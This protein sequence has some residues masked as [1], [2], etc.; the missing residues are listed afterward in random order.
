MRDSRDCSKSR[1]RS[2]SPFPDRKLNERRKSNHFCMVSSYCR[3]RHV[4]TDHQPWNDHHSCNRSL[5]GRYYLSDG[6]RSFSDCE[7]QKDP[8]RV[9]ELRHRG[10]YR[11]F[12]SS[13][14]RISWIDLLT[15][16][17]Y[18]ERHF[19]ARPRSSRE[20]VNWFHRSSHS[21]P[22]PNHRNHQR[23]AYCSKELRVIV[24]DGHSMLPNV[25]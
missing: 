15:N 9:S 22:M 11:Y 19:H 6:A 20:V 13:E 2:G 23:A 1:D 24:R 8:M 12:F 25:S 7:L 3:C 21:C 16:E 4:Y 5:V 17:I 10:P 18:W 14:L